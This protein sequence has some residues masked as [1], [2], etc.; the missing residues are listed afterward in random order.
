MSRA[1][2]TLL[3]AGGGIVLAVV[4]AAAM[5]AWNAHG[6][7]TPEDKAAENSAERSASVS[8][9]SAGRPAVAVATTVAREMLFE[10]RLSIA[11]SV[12]AKRFALV[13][14]RVP[15][16]LDQVFVDA[17][18]VVEAGTTK[19]FQTDSLKLEQAAAIARQQ[20]TVAECSVREKQALLE[21]TQVALEQALADLTRYRQLR[22]QNAI[23]QQIVEHQAAQCRQLETDVR[24]TQSLIELAQAQLE[25]A[26]LN[27]RIAQKDLSDS[28]VTAPISGRVSLR[29][30]EP[31]EMAA[32]GTPVVRIDDGSLVELSVFVPAEYYDRVQPGAT[33]LRARVGSVLLTD[34]P[35]TF[36][37]PTV[38]SRLRTFQVKA[39][40]D[41]PPAEVVPGALAQVELILTARQGVGVP[42]A[43]VVQR[44]GQ[45]VVFTVGPDGTARRKAVELG[46]ETDGWR[47][48][49]RGVSA[50]AAVISMGQ[51]M[52]DEGTAVR[53]VEEA[54]R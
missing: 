14:A 16:T 38:E 10:E 36:K 28:L 9:A 31:G 1:K 51:S 42:G 54:G 41:A 5:V 19:L 6:A 22:E 8:S 20:L 48:I 25:Q 12:L 11:G 7:A 15:G 4:F 30:K 24:H 37:S 29:L 18:D 53:V 44:D 47:E 34:L 13:S 26:R 52:V 33:K 46:L 35:V 50:G 40:V 23:A 43:A 17:G 45:S 39:L 3:A 2:Q 27:Y 32:A 21:K 49:R